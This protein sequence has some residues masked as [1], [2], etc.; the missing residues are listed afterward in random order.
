MK[1]RGLDVLKSTTII[2][3]NNS[4]SAAPRGRTN[5]ASGHSADSLSSDNVNNGNNEII[6]PQISN[7]PTLLETIF[8]WMDRIR[9]FLHETEFGRGISIIFPF[10]GLILLGAVVVGPLEGWT[11]LEALYF[12][13]VSLTTVGEFVNLNVSCKSRMSI[14]YILAH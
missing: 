10:A 5:S 12:S 6:S 1:R 9:R 2:S 3:P 11:F 14:S 13:V 7:V 8:R 4:D